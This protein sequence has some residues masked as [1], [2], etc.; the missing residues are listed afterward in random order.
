MVGNSVIKQEKVLNRINFDFNNFHLKS[1]LPNILSIFRIITSP[2]LFILI[3]LEGYLIAFIL[4]TT[5]GVTDILDGYLARKF[6]VCSKNGVFLDIFG[7]FLFLFS[8]LI[9]FTIKE[10]YP[11]WILIIVTIMFIQFFF[12]F[13]NETPIYDPIGKH[14]GSFLMIILTITI[15]DFKGFLTIFILISFII[16]TILSIISRILALKSISENIINSK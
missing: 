8:T 12:F 3:L 1:Y 14:Y 5:D 6:D 2:L 16:F 11:F 10:T 9:A 15:I 7:D 13:N 4:F